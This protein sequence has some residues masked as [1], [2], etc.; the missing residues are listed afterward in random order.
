MLSARRPNLV[1]CPRPRQ[2]RVG[3]KRFCRRLR[4]SRLATAVEAAKRA[5]RLTSA[6]A[7]FGISAAAA[8]NRE[9][10]RKS[11][12][13][14]NVCVSGV[15]FDAVNVLAGSRAR[16][17]GAGGARAVSF[18]REGAWLEART[19]KR[20]RTGSLPFRRALALPGA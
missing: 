13:G 14:G 1:A 16:R 2:R 8:D 15:C 10:N 19:P 18:R 17:G 6:K 12:R 3:G 5:Y 4:Q 9:A 20:T 7:S 11:P